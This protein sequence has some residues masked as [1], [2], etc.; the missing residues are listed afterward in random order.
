[1]HSLLS[2]GFTRL[3]LS[4]CCLLVGVNFKQWIRR[5]IPSPIYWE[6][7]FVIFFFDVLYVFTKLTID[8]RI[9]TDHGSCFYLFATFVCS[10][11]SHWFRERSVELCQNRCSG[12][13]LY[14]CILGNSKKTNNRQLLT[15][16]HLLSL[17][18]F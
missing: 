15:D 16:N 4:W 11:Y 10:H 14:W 12:F 8:A 2:N 5:A 17:N 1:M 7:G 6:I 18:S 3:D 13:N 9:E